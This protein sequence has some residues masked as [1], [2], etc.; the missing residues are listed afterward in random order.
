MSHDWLVWIPALLTLAVF[1]F[2]Y[3]DN[4]F[5]KI[6]EHIFVGVSAGWL[7]ATYFHADILEDML[8][9]AFPRFFHQSSPPNFIPLFGGVIGLA[10]L[11]RLIPGFVWLSR[12]AVAF[13][14][15]F[16]TGLQL[17]SAISANILA[18]LQST[19]VPLFVPKN[20]AQ[21]LKNW[22]MT[23]GTFSSLSYFYFSKEQKGAF[24]VLTRLGIWFLMISFGAAY[25]S[26][27]MTRMSILI[28]RIYF[29]LSI[30]LGV[31]K[32]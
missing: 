4:I 3:K 16:Q 28:G 26:T 20:I 8:L 31:V 18:Q 10:I 19:L 11:S 15:G 24:G 6:A 9:K 14:V 30:W 7:F 32:T 17:F 12:W 13:V 1:S 27:V 21:T 2:L 5:Y 25:G 22:L 23:L 29:L